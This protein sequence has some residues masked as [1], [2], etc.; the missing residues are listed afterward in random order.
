MKEIK[1]KE[2]L[3][4]QLEAKEIEIAELKEQI[5][6]NDMYQEFR[7][8]ADDTHLIKES[9]VDAGFTNEQAFRL[10]RDIVVGALKPKSL[11]GGL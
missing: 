2:F 7:K 10:T 11:L 6:Q 5:A 3:E 4:E 1:K 9:F 8:A